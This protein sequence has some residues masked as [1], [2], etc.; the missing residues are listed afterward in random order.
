MHP[1]LRIWLLFTTGALLLG[2]AALLQR[3]ADPVAAACNPSGSDST[4]AAPPV[5]AAQQRNPTDL[6]LVQAAGEK[7]LDC[8]ADQ[9]RV[10]ALAVEEEPVESLS[11]GPG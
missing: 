9:E 1:R 11:S 6:A 3:A 4:S 2:G 5:S 8:H 10:K 7:C